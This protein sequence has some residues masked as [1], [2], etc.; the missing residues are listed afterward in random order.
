MRPIFAGLAAF[1]LGWGLAA[2]NYGGNF[3]QFGSFGGKAE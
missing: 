3:L 1:L 2:N